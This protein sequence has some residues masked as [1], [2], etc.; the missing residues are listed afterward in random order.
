MP[1][2]LRAQF[3]VA[4][5]A[6]GVLVVAGGAT[7]VYALYTTS[8]A[9]REFSQERL[10]LM[11]SAQDLQQRTQQI[12]LL[13]DRMVA[14]ESSAAARRSYER[15]LEE[16]DALDA[17]TA[18]L[19]V[20]DD[21][22]VLDLHMASQLFRSSAHV[23]AYARESASLPG[24]Q[25]VRSAAL[26][27][28]RDEMQLH[29]DAMTRAARE[30]SGHVTRTYQ[31]AVQRVVDASHVSAYWV[32][33]W[34]AFSLLSAWLIARLLLGR[35][36][37]A[38]L[39]QVSRSLRTVDDGSADAPACVPVHG[40]DEIGAMARAVEQFLSDRSQLALTRARLEEEQQR[41]SAIIDN[42]ADSIVVLQAGTVVQVNR[43]AERM[44]GVRHAQA[45][46]LPVERLM[47]GFEWESLTLPG[48][49][50]DAFARSGDERTIPVEVSLNPVSSGGG[51][52]VVLVIRDATLRREAEQHL[53]AA[54]DAAVAA[55]AA[56]ATFLAT[57]SHEL[58]TPL[59]AVLGY[60]QILERDPSLS[61]R[62]QFAVAT[63]HRSGDHLL[64][65]I[66]DLLDLAKHDA[67]K[68]EL[69]L[70]D[71]PL[72]ECLRVTADIVRV[73]AEEAG[74]RFVVDIAQE[75]PSTIV[76]DEKRLRQ[77][78]LNL[79]SNAVK[80]TDRGEVALRV[81]RVRGNARLARL[82][83]EVRDTG[84]G[85]PA[86]QLEMIFHPFEQTGDARRR[87]IGSGLGLAISRELVR[88]MGGDLH[89]SSV[90]GR[91]AT[92]WFELDV[93]V[94]PLGIGAT[95]G[96]AVIGYE[97]PRRRILVVD[98][99]PANRLVLRDMLLPLGFEVDEAGDGRQALESAA[100]TP[101][102]LIVMDVEMPVM[103][104]M[105]AMALIHEIES[106]RRVP[107][108]AMSA[109]VDAD[110]VAVGPGEDA[111][112]FLSKPLDRDRLLR[113]IAVR[114]ELRWIAGS[115]S[116]EDV[117]PAGP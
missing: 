92:F 9:A 15:I 96:P 117:T 24:A 97:G 53:I 54:R 85:I 33:A 27:D 11:Q 44:F 62:Q 94:A 42:T 90:P 93:L 34:L 63:I 113:E 2:S 83:F 78:L 101:P 13:A 68:L 47:P 88:L 4:L 21:V 71:L 114:L 3:A 26:S 59:N 14:A 60:A 77:V 40:D 41:L 84:V 105:Q 6:M 86:D 75:V 20:G 57:M 58:R 37:V 48:V 103:G 51:D 116:L 80:F 45:A 81:R 104:G 19:A 73:K 108:L 12:Q 76:G 5:F 95:A 89:V 35:H 17:L 99:L 66:N 43:A 30:Q 52:L 115:P 65:L 23:I 49:T 100:S 18:R 69:F 98:D 72:L 109:T 38:R 55:R 25:A 70:D 39:Q 28:Y 112:A 36:V 91:G 22:S 82:R 111:V 8:S 79:L 102:D 107:I 46:G 67:G 74:L 106:L 56:Q 7:A 87:T 61:Q 110:A 31:A 16:L 1:H 10:A 50:R 64:A 32:V 29:A